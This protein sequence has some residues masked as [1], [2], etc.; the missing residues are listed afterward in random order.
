[1]NRRRLRNRNMKTFSL[2]RSIRYKYACKKLSCHRLLSVHVSP[3]LVRIVGVCSSAV[4]IGASRTVGSSTCVYSWTPDKLTTVA[5]STAG[6][7][8]SPWHTG[9]PNCNN[10]A[11]VGIA[12]SFSYNWF[13]ILCATAMCP[14]CELDIP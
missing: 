10:E 7:S 11:C 14:L 3:C 12:G 8:S 5:I 2:N 1:M 6:W 9:D 4:W 13:D